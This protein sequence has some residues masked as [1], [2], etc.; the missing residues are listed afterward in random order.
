M[1]GG[2][3]G[4]AP[5]TRY[6]VAAKRWLAN[7]GGN[8]NSSWE[9]YKCTNVRRANQ[10]APHGGLQLKRF[11]EGCRVHSVRPRGAMVGSGEGAGCM[12]A[13]AGVVGRCWN[14]GGRVGTHEMKRNERQGTYC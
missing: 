4:V 7:C 3:C 8:G 12:H 13:A 5:E 1:E 11:Y 6:A 10:R 14:T 9:L 2:D